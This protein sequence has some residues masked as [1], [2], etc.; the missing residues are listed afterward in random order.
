MITKCMAYLD[1]IGLHTLDDRIITQAIREQRA[2]SQYTTSTT[3][4][5]IGQMITSEERAFAETIVEFSIRE[6]TNYADRAEILDKVNSWAAG[7]GLLTVNYRPGKRQRVFCYSLIN[8]GFVR[9]W[10]TTYSLSFRTLS[11]PFWENETKTTTASAITANEDARFLIDPGGT[12]KTT[13]SAI[14]T[15]DGADTINS[16]KISSGNQ[17]IHLQSLG[18]APGEVFTM[19][20]DENGILVLSVTGSGIS[21]SVL[22]KRTQDSNDDIMLIPAENSVTVNA[23]GSASVTLS[24]RGRWL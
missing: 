1:G 10:T 21:R 16:M 12:E 4:K 17:M 8:V 24:A 20:E 6:R 11:V 23:D 9:E 7:G 2:D 19:Q 3:A 13:L 14:V 18:L 15:N 5:R 22:A